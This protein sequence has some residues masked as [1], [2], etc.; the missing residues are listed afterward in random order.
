MGRIWITAENGG[1]EEKCLEAVFSRCESCGCP[2]SKGQVT[3]SCAWAQV[4]I[5]I[6]SRVC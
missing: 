6:G 4:Q 5:D 1:G 3:G 2:E